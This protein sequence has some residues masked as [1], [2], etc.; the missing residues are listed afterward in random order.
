MSNTN[1]LRVTLKADVNGWD[2]DECEA[3]SHREL[4]ELYAE[5]LRADA[6]RLQD[7][8]DRLRALADYADQLALVVEPC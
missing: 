2:V 8:V 3:K 4:F 7:D 6:K 5:H 1:Y